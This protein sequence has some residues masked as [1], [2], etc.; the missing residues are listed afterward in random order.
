MK[1]EALKA[2]SEFTT[3]EFGPYFFGPYE[4]PLITVLG[5]LILL[6]LLFLA[7][8]LVLWIALPFSVFGIKGLLKKAIKEQEK[9]NELLKSLIGSGRGRENPPGGQ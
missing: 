1:V 4:G 5:V 2:A 6:I 3:R 8:V 9:T 7:V